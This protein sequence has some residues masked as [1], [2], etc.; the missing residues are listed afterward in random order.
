MAVNTIPHKVNHLK[1]VVERLTNAHIT[2]EDQPF[3]PRQ[4]DGQALTDLISSGEFVPECPVC[5]ELPRPGPVYGCHNGH[6]F[7]QKCQ[8]ELKFCP[9]CRN[10]DLK[11]RQIVLE[12]TLKGLH[13]NEINT[14]RCKHKNCAVSGRHDQL[15]QH[16]QLCLMRPIQCPIYSCGFTGTWDE[17]KEHA[18]KMYCCAI[19]TPTNEDDDTEIAISADYTYKKEPD[20]QHILFSDRELVFRPGI[21]DDD[22]LAIAGGAYATINRDFKGN[23]RFGIRCLGPPELS[24]KWEVKII[25]TGGDPDSPTHTFE[26]QAMSQES[27]WND[28]FVQSGHYLTL[29]DQQV[30]NLMTSETEEDHLFI[31]HYRINLQAE[32]RC[33]YTA[34]AHGYFVD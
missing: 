31:C 33:N 27:D 12:Q 29:N 17:Y 3:Q 2:D 25:V 15:Q 4:F 32:F 34:I 5:L 26:G 11:C 16:E 30:K 18:S 21:L 8:E 1:K 9:I 14:Y 28:S 23:W 6:H 13:V 10:R 7:C 20:S 19:L 22:R 24:K